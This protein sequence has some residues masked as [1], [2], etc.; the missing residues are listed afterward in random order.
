M[1][2]QSLVDQC[3]SDKEI[4]LVCLNH[5]IH[6]ES[7]DA[8]AIE[9]LFD[10][11]MRTHNYQEAFECA[12]KLWELDPER[13]SDYGFKVADSYLL[14]NKFDESLNVYKRLLC[15]SL[16]CDDLIKAE[17]GV[18]QC[19]LALNDLDK[20]KSFF[21]GVLEKHPNSYGSLC[22]MAIIYE[23]LGQP[24]EALNQLNRAKEVQPGHDF[25]KDLIERIHKRLNS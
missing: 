15:S 14:Y 19:Y 25:A 9:I 1:S 11:Y 18:A 10:L 21:D 6:E 8:M 16:G 7:F 23:K 13:Y 12:D 3:Q 22:G 20:A 2:I 24:L 4:E 5:L 17:F